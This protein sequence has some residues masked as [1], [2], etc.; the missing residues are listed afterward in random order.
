MNNKNNK[1]LDVSD[2]KFRLEISK[3]PNN[4]DEDKLKVKPCGYF[5][6]L[7]M[8]ACGITQ[9]FMFLNRSSVAVSILSMV[10]HTHVAMHGPNHV[11]NGDSEV[12][13]TGLFLWN[14]EIQQLIVS[15][16][17]LAY[18]VSIR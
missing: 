2:G 8:I 17:M 1:N 5:R 14:N 6:Y 18:V 16:Y 15:S 3:P 13:D 9:G 4:E 7:L 11:K 10:N 12:D